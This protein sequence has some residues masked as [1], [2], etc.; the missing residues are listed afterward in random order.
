MGTSGDV[1]REILLPKLDGIRKSGGSYMA[2]CPA[3]DDSTASLSITEG[4]DHPVILKCHAGCEPEDILAKLGLTWETLC[5]PRED[6]G[7][8][9]GEW[10]PN[11][12]A[13]AVYD[14]RDEAGKLL[15]QACRSAGKKFSQRVPDATCKSGWRWSLEGT[16][17]V[18]YRLPKVIE[19]VR[20]GELIY[21]C[22]ADDTEVLTPSG[23][24][25]M[26]KLPPGAQVAQYDV[27]QVSFVE[28]SARQVFDYAG[29]MVS[30][31]ADWSGLLVTP[32]HRT[33]CRWR[34]SRPVTIRAADVKAQRW[35]PVAGVRSG[36]GSGPTADEARLLAAWQADGVDCP[37]GHRVAWNLRKG[38]KKERLRKL[39]A[40]V[41]IEWREQ[42]FP[43]TPGWTY[44]SIDRRDAPVLE[45]LAG[46]RFG[47]DIL[48]WSAESRHAL[49]GELGYWDGD[50][51]GREGVRYF[52][53]DEQCAEV[54][55]AIAATTG[56][57][58]IV[59][60]DDRDAR[61]EQGP[62]W[63]VSLVP[64]D[65]RTLGNEPGR[66]DYDGR[67]YCLTVPS[68]Y[69]VTRRQGKVTVCGNCEGEKDVH[70]VEAAGM[71]ATCNPMGA[72]K[73][74]EEYTGFLRDATV[75]IVADRDKP[76]Q[77]HARQVATSLQGVAA[78]IEIAE[79][80]GEGTEGGDKIKDV[81]DHLAAGRGLRDLVVTWTSDEESPIDLAPDLHEF[82][83]G[84]DPP[85][86]WIVESI[87]ERGDRL[88]WT[89]FEGLGKSV[90]MRQIAIGA[91][92]GIHPF[93]G[94]A[95]I[96]R[97]VLWIDCENSARQ[98]RRM[99]R[100][101]ERVT[102]AKGHRVPA[103]GMRLIHR[104]EGLDLMGD[105]DVA[106][107]LER[108]T[109]HKPDLLYIGPLYR[110]HDGDI[111]EE[112]VMRRIVKTLDQARIK[113]D[114]ALMVEH[115]SPHGD[116]ANRSVRPIGSSLLRR[117]PECGYG[118][119]PAVDSDPCTEV[120]VLPW[121]GNRD[122]RHWPKFLSWGTRDDDWPWVV[123]P[124]AVAEAEA[125]AAESWSPSTAIGDAE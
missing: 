80:A 37:R 46:K 117:W 73:W 1:L 20:N 13:I 24:V 16:R 22:Y 108:V 38:R 27:G 17:R 68:G 39:L 43:S 21:I 58:S 45:R 76:G 110:L 47:W 7:R 35:L 109:A 75:I 25:L 18:L 44:L 60:R 67:V 69:L 63:V 56:W 3:H 87:L 23:W 10:T 83:A 29:P 12:E 111:N 62:Q 81:A 79:A 14:Y 104:P 123:P 74:R 19:A 6:D 94:E 105:E 125:R 113:V 30:M 9:R 55:S 48:D 36:S 32:D 86:D 97:K 61:P 114:C 93:T 119:A 91:A 112:R 121:R 51:P 84:T 85:Y 33:L 107:L 88:V 15:F 90:T 28:P 11:G 59:R 70:A 72:G 5:S 99:F 77:A 115:H 66:E 101:L 26:A 98:G 42:E 103:G 122:E 82:L 40:A 65:W 95:A 100:K 96:A 49:L 118:L 8:T 78:A 92:A 31:D 50:R 102:V 4:K 54:V 52:T 53:A 124:D 41:G 57:G 64:R 120:R 116:G 71:T 34:E 89:G 2:R 106:W